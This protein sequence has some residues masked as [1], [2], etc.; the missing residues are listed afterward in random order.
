MLKVIDRQPD[1]ILSDLA[2]MYRRQR[3]G[4]A[5]ELWLA[6]AK[7][8]GTNGLYTYRAGKTLMSLGR[9]VEAAKQL[10][11]SLKAVPDH[12]PTRYCRAKCLACSGAFEEAIQ[13]AKA[14]VEAQPQNVA[15]QSLFLHILVLT[16]RFEEALDR[17]PS[18]EE[19]RD[20]RTDV[21]AHLVA[22]AGRRQMPP[23]SELTAG[24]RRQLASVLKEDPGSAAWTKKLQRFL[25]R[26]QPEIQS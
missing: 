24:I 3:P 4:Q 9:Y 8:D 20:S 26:C 17:F 21:L 7:L 13:E 11:R 1:E 10:G 2:H 22:S 15:A 19:C 6:A 16:Q 25:L 23:E 18:L 14:V 5:V 12:I